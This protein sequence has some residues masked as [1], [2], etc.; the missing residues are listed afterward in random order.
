LRA[1]LRSARI[2]LDIPPTSSSLA[3]EKHV[4]SLLLSTAARDPGSNCLALAQ[5][6]I[7]LGARGPLCGHRSGHAQRVLALHLRVVAMSPGVEGNRS[8]DAEFPTV[9]L[10]HA[11]DARQVGG[12]RDHDHEQHHHHILI[13][14]EEDRWRWRR[15][16]RQDKRKLAVYRAAVGLLG[17]VLIALGFVS[18]P[19]PGTGGIPLVLIGVG[20]WSREFEWAPQ[21]I[22]WFKGKLHLYRTWSSG[23]RI[24]FWVAFF[25]CCGI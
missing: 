11:H 4:C 21:L 16:I 6:G 2:A 23:K 5:R 17:L 20:G 8:G 18:G 9:T 12:H 14:P 22:Q 7:N 24:L 13:E 25:G 19:I 1:P 10:P 3:D 15:K